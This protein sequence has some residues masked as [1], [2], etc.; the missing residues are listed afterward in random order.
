MVGMECVWRLYDR[1]E[2]TFDSDLV[3]NEAGVLVCWSLTAMKGNTGSRDH[4]EE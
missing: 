2:L 4:S 1:K 3:V